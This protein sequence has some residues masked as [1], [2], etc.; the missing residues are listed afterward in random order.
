MKNSS[1]IIRNRTRDLPACSAVPQLTAPPRV[2]VLDIINCISTNLHAFR[3]LPRSKAKKTWI[4]LFWVITQRVVVISNRRSGTTYRS[5]LQVS[6][7]LAYNPKRVEFSCTNLALNSLCV[8][9]WK[10]AKLRQ[11][12]L[13][14]QKYAHK[15]VTYNLYNSGPLSLQVQGLKSNRLWKWDMRFCRQ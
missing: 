2:P 13:E 8:I 7:I 3:L 9:N 14:V 5:H 15:Q 1:D 12:W 10:Y 6:R 11:S 4:A